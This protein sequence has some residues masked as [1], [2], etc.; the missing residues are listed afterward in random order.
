[1]NTLLNAPEV[2]IWM[3]DERH[4]CIYVNRAVLEYTGKQAHEMMGLDWMSIVHPEDLDMVR[5]NHA[6]A[7]EQPHNFRQEYRVLALDGEVRWALDLSIARFDRKNKFLGYI[8]VV[9]DITEQKREE[10]QLRSERRELERQVLG[11]ADREQ[12]RLGQDLHDGLSQRLLAVALKGDLL[13]EGLTRKNPKAAAA[14]GR[15]VAEVNRAIRE[16]REISRS[17][18]PIALGK[19]RLGPALQ[20]LFHY[21]RRQFRVA[22]RTRG[23][24]RDFGL[25]LDASVHLYRIVQEALTNAV[26]HGR[27]K[28]IEI[29]ARKEKNG[30][31]TVKVRDRGKGLPRRIGVSGM[32]LA[33]MR[34]RA[35][36]LGGALDLRPA[37]GGGAE[38]SLALPARKNRK[39]RSP[40]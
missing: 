23:L 15:I 6:R 8:G 9:T 25:D 10:L 14:A 24:P 17:L 39:E 4:L 37:A 30:G 18:A 26:R 35:E 13:R 12:R 20:E 29:S 16:T 3:T 1:L 34:Y 31:L 28:R 38:L 33:T 19:N 22:V 7:R 27:A 40:R 5:R 21:V 36:L 2:M 11:I 32:G